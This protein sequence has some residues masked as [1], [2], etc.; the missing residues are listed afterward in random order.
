M[1]IL[2]KQRQAR[3]GVAVFFIVLVTCLIGLRVFGE[4]VP[5]CRDVDFW[6][7]CRNLDKARAQK[8]NTPF[9]AFLGSSRIACGVR[10][11]P[12]G[13]DGVNF[14]FASLGG[15]PV[16]D[17]FKSSW[18]I[19][20][21]KKPSLLVLEAWSEGLCLGPVPQRWLPQLAVWERKIYSQWAQDPS[22]YS[23]PWDY[24][25]NLP[26]DL[27]PPVHYFFPNWMPENFRRTIR[28]DALGGMSHDFKPSDW[29]P[30][31]TQKQFQKALE[32]NA[33]FMKEFHPQKVHLAALRQQL[34]MCRAN[35]IPVLFVLA[36]S[37]Q[38]YRK[39][40][41][42]AHLADSRKFWK[43]LEQ[44]FGCKFVDSSNWGKESDFFDGYHLFD[45]S[46][47]LYSQWLGQRIRELG[48]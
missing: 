20:L 21:G 39:E 46:A 13:L 27:D 16:Q 43:S 12:L 9:R 33:P 35:S 14:N 31:R 2:E 17:Y 6:R 15:N 37:S 26:K 42:A 22:F 32:G 8:P 1:Q 44:E 40:Y 11:T 3:R 23:G 29:T 25:G 34:E 36:P 19:Q 48:L 28:F 45:D 4:T 18:L 41:G 10:L 47:D 38:A 7:R 24:L 30:E 5:G